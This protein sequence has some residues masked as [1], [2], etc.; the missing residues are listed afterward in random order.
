MGVDNKEGY[1]PNIVLLKLSHQHLH[2]G[3]NC[4]LFEG[5]W[6]ILHIFVEPE[7]KCLARKACGPYS[8]LLTAGNDRTMGL[9]NCQRGRRIGMEN[10]FRRHG[11]G[12]WAMRRDRSSGSK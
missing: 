10:E 7:S 5:L 8:R 4:R 12:I 6:N 11:G 9:P 1:S 3:R 2:V